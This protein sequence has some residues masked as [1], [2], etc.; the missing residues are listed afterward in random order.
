MVLQ[1]AL[2]VLLHRLGAGDD[3]PIGTPIAGRTDEALDDLVGFFVNTWCCAPTCPATRRSASCSR[4]VRDTAL[5][6]YAHQDVPFERLVEALNPDALHRPYHPLFQVMLAWQNNADADSTCPGLGV[7]FEQRA[8]PRPPSSTCS[9]ASARRRRATAGCGLPGVR[10]RPVR[11]R[12]RAEA[13]ADRFVRVLRQVVAD[14][15]APVG[16]VDVLGAAERR[17]G[18][19]RAERHR[20]AGAAR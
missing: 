20:G 6:A 15:A 5:A 17:A 18:A 8:R 14:P 9:S 2:A 11:P 19:A 1:A 13:S 10:H 12:R 16:A 4:R 3:I 7:E